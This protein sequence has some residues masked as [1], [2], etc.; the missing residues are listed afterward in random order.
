MAKRMISAFASQ[1]RQEQSCLACQEWNLIIYRTNDF[2][3]PLGP[4]SIIAWQRL[5]TVIGTLWG[6]CSEWAKMAVRESK[7]RNR[8]TF[9]VELG[10]RLIFG[11]LQ[12]FCVLANRSGIAF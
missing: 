2:P 1:S 8:K 5:T 3:R 12:E 4:S 6:H 9:L 7:S 10:R 11:E